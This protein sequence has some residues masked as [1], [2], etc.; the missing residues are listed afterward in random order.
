MATLDAVCAAI[1]SYR[2]RFTN[3]KELQEGIAGALEREGIEATREVHL[4]PGDIPDFMVEPGLAVEVK[5]AGSPHE[6]MR[7]LSRY[8][9][10]PRVS[11]L[12][13]VTRKA[14][15]AHQFPDAIGGKPLRVSVLEGCAL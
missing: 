4:A 14:Q 5:V 8:A 15:H 12:L 3:E 13:L 6:I 7:Q 9:A 11:E 10:S 1:R 2:Y